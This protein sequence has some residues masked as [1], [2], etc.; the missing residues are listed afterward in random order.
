[1]VH[2]QFKLVP[3]S[4]RLFHFTHRV[5]IAG[6]ILP[7]SFAEARRLHVLV[8]PLLRLTRDQL[9]LDLE[10]GAFDQPDVSRAT[11]DNLELEGARPDSFGRSKQGAGDV[12]KD[13]AVPGLSDA[14]LPGFF[15]PLELGAQVVV[16]VLVLRHNAAEVIS[17]NVNDSLLHLEDLIGVVIQPF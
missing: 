3:F 16:F 15:A 14:V 1:M 9:T 7:G 17:G 8:W 4:V 10:A 12:V 11:F 13:A 6:Y 2:D 5:A